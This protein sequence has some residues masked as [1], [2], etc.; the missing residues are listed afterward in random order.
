MQIAELATRPNDYLKQCRTAAGLSQEELAYR[1]D[2]TQ[3]GISQIETGKVQPGVSRWLELVALCNPD[4]TISQQR[5]P[6]GI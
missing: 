3:A 4:A 1:A 5:N 2:M 6:D